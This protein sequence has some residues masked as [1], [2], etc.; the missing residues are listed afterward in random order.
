MKSLSAHNKSNKSNNDKQL[1]IEFSSDEFWL[2]LQQFGPA[3][4]LGI[5][6][7]HLGWLIEEIEEADRNAL[8]SLVDRGIVRVVSKNQ[9]ELDDALAA[10][11]KTCAHPRHTLIT[12]FQ[13]ADGANKQRYIHF[14]DN[15]IVEH[16][17]FKRGHHRVTAIKH[18]GAL[19]EHLDEVLRLS[20]TASSR[21]GKFKIPESTLFEARALC[22]DGETRKASTNLKKAKL[23]EEKAAMLAKALS[24][25]VANSAFAM[26]CNQDKPQVQNVKG[27]ALLEGEKDFWILLP[28]D[29]GDE[30]LVEF[31]PANSKLV[32]Q[33]FLEILP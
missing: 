12:Q 18:Q 25:P 16:M 21:G 6:N 1:S 23:S 8:R 19:V 5:K 22:K 4:A 7:P 14:G 31:I 20:S 13:N 32:K 11:I 29:N 28:H 3:V 17:E 10:M 9:I 27:F 33:R 30:K 26:L 15:L 24:K 2:L